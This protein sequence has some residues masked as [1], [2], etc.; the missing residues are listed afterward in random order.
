M[1]SRPSCGAPRALLAIDTAT[2]RVSVALVRDGDLVAVRDGA[3]RDSSARLIGWIDAVLR[4]GGATLADLA[5]AVALRGPGSFTGLRVGLATLLGFHQACGLAVTALPTLQVLAG[6]ATSASGDADLILDDLI[7]ALVPAGPTEWFAQPFAASWPP[8][9]LD[10]ARRLPTSALVAE[11]LPSTLQ[12]GAQRRLELVVA[13]QE[14]RDRLAATVTAPI[15]VAPLLAPVA[16]RLA[17]TDLPSWDAAL[18]STPLYLA[19]PP[20]TIPGTPKPV[21]PF[22]GGRSR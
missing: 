8:R 12:D 21:L 6:A 3:Q 4:E 19:P 7:L 2:P 20:V 10:E 17:E 1:S 9:A 13:A 15:R 14:E 5:G 22:N 16:G 18:L 11:P